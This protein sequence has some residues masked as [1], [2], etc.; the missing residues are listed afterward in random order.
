MDFPCTQPHWCW[1]ENNLGA[2]F[3][4]WAG[5]HRLGSES[6]HQTNSLWSQVELDRRKTQLLGLR[7]V[8]EKQ[9]L[10]LQI[11]DADTQQKHVARH[12]RRQDLVAADGAVFVLAAVRAPVL[13]EAVEIVGAAF[14]GTFL[15][16]RIM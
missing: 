7:I 10:A 3:W 8:I 6:R 16:P 13:L 15:P 9:V 1:V 4:L 12:A 14:L 5:F 11:V 2:S